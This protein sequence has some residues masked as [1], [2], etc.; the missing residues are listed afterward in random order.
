MKKTL[1]CL[2]S[3][4]SLGIMYAHEDTSIKTDNFMVESYQAADEYQQFNDDQDLLLEEELEYEQHI[5]DNVNPPKPSS[6]R[7]ILTRIGCTLLIH[8]I[9]LTEKAKVYLAALKNRLAKI[10]CSNS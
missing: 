6:I 10:L 9:T 1:L 2:M 4:L 8:Y 5:C 7:V 3:F